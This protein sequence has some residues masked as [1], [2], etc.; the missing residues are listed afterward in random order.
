MEPL[1]YDWVE[2]IKTQMEQQEKHLKGL[3]PV[4]KNPKNEEISSR[5]SSPQGTYL[6]E[7]KRIQDSAKPSLQTFKIN[8]QQSK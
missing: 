4:G 8:L 2:A 1:L 5:E 3:G 6:L 7:K